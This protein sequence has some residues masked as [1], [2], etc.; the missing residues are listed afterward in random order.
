MQLPR[1]CSLFWHSTR[2]RR[3][4]TTPFSPK[5]LQQKHHVAPCTQLKLHRTAVI[6]EQ[7]GANTP[8][9]RAPVFTSMGMTILDELRF[10]H[11][12]TVYDM[13]GGSGLFGTSIVPRFVLI[14]RAMSS[15]LLTRQVSCSWGPTVQTWSRRRRRGMRGYCWVR[16]AR[17]TTL[18]AEVLGTYSTCAH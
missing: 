1:R 12:K 15:I 13:P 18:T 11:Q 5:H 3:I 8:P 14:S 4:L 2:R 7:N 16:H 10:S 6:M 9:E 17:A